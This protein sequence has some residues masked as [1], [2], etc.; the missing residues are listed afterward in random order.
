MPEP[1]NQG[2]EGFVLAGG[3][4]ARM[5]RDKALLPWQGQT[6]LE[7]A[8]GATRAVAS[9]TRIVGSKAKFESYGS[10][11]EDI[12]P[13]R[14]PLGGIH[15][16]LS[17]SDRE[18]NLV[19]A[20]DLPFVTAELLAYLIQRAQDSLHMA[21][22]PRLQA[23]WEPLCAVYRREFVKVAE[24]ALRKGENVIHSLL[25]DG[26]PMNVRAGIHAIGEEELEEAGF[27]APIFRNINTIADFEANADETRGSTGA[28]AT[29]RG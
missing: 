25:G 10:V 11:V 16:A 21:T 28:T 12:F 9:V 1:T 26:A 5:G 3:K 4:S 29:L 6:L 23:G 8:L 19:L 27:P 7:R 20:V 24:D 14:G 2:V 22:V 18:L 17:D 15:A 13:E